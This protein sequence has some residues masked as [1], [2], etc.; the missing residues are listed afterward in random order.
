[1]NQKLFVAGIFLFF[2]LCFGDNLIINPGFEN[3]D[4]E[5]KPEYWKC[6]AGGEKDSIVIDSKVIKSGKNSL[7]L[8]HAK[9]DSYSFVEQ[10]IDV[11]TNTQYLFSAF[12]NTLNLQGTGGFT[13][14]LI[15]GSSGELASLVYTAEQWKR[16]KADFNSG[17]NSKIQISCWLY[18]K[19]GSVW[20]DDLIL[21]VAPTN[22]KQEASLVQCTWLF[23]ES[24]DLDD[25]T[26]DNFIEPRVENGV[27]IGK[28]VCVP[29]IK[30]PFMYTPEKDIEAS[31]YTALKF[32]I[33]CP[34]SGNGTVYFRKKGEW[35]S[36]AN[37][38]RFT[39]IG[40]SAFRTYTIPI[41]NNNWN[42]IIQ[43]LRITFIYQDNVEIE[44]PYFMITGASTG[45]TGGL[46]K[47][48]SFEEPIIQGQT[49]GWKMTGNGIIFLHSKEKAS[50]LETALKITGI[51][52]GNIAA[53][54]VYF[55]FLDSPVPYNFSFAYLLENSIAGTD[56][57][58]RIAFQDS[59]YKEF[60]IIERSVEIISSEKFQT[61]NSQIYIPP[62]A[63]A[64]SVMLEFNFHG[65]EK[66][67]I[68]N[69]VFSDADL[70]ELDYR[71]HVWD[72]WQSEWIRPGLQDHVTGSCFFRKM[73]SLTQK[74]VTAML[75]IT[76]DD[77]VTGV[78]IN[79]KRLVLQKNSGNW[80]A[81]DKY[82][83]AQ[84]LIS[85]NNI[86][87]VE[88]FNRATWGGLLCEIGIVQDNGDHV[89]IKSDK[90]FKT[91][92]KLSEGWEKP[93][94]NDNTWQVPYSHG[95]APDA[96][97]WT[98]VPHE[99][100]GPKQI[101]N[102]NDI[103][104]PAEVTCG[105]KTAFSLK[106]NPADSALS[107]FLKMRNQD[108]ITTIF[109]ADLSEL[110]TEVQNTFHTNFTM[111]KIFSRGKTADFFM[112]SERVFFKTTQSG[113]E[114]KNGELI[115]SNTAIQTGPPEK[116]SIASFCYTSGKK[117]VLLLN[118][119]KK[120]SFTS[121]DWEFGNV[122]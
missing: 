63:A 13:R 85:G 62:L 39:L 53:W 118:G 72:N 77:E 101:V 57:N 46:I 33:K 16:K 66:L 91:S 94:F 115:I 45:N 113:I 107:F 50:D 54:D 19:S 95:K 109:R 34:V 102:I 120:R 37:T 55:D 80:K 11:S 70:P 58:F 106:F 100:T 87:A 122:N 67:F 73:F 25:W 23:S 20:F 6:T 51:G 110:S 108:H 68:D 90:S 119:E 44:I 27:F 43:Q 38:I 99:Y 78:F 69:V 7:L 29:G 96:Y 41:K 111:P 89:L 60:K 14:I 104:F 30:S 21:S 8:S 1:M 4:T 64:A 71:S 116:L 31:N 2:N 47:N 103:Q 15:K 32:S 40:D 88:T 105:K 22:P 61:F 112:T 86:F 75:V 98:G 42:G 35:Y 79:G 9:T 84:Y 76:A 114:N 5:K 121:L 81:M 93:S 59:F 12:V 26:I 48:G 83:I 65:K 17:A 28:T 24:E 117:P 56:I 49:D 36:E 3:T 92:A 97:P 18:K 52:K 82:E 74:A 10:T